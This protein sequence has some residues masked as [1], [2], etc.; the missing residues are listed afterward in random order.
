MILRFF[1]FMAEKKYRFSGFVFIMSLLMLINSILNPF[2]SFSK[3]EIIT[4]YFY[5]PS[6]I[7]YSYNFIICG[8]LASVIENS[9]N[10]L[11]K[12]IRY[13]NKREYF[14][15]I[16]KN[17]FLLCL[18][19]VITILVL[20]FLSMIIYNDN[21]YTSELFE[22]FIAKQKL[23]DTPMIFILK[24]SIIF[25]FYFYFLSLFYY[26]IKFIT[27]NI[28]LSILLFYVLTFS[29]YIFSGYLMREREVNFLFLP[30][31]SAFYGGFKNLGEFSSA[32]GFLIALSTLIFYIVLEIV[33]LNY[34]LN[35]KDLE[36]SLK[37]RKNI[38]N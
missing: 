11:Y 33:I 34:L 8:F 28:N 16:L 12:L 3:V 21:T 7:G 20:S 5:F 13:Q 36:L 29:G 2:Y 25:F 23:T 27:K 18:F 17:L 22:N 24:K 30:Y 15:R 35:N 6:I 14:K 32:G 4:K 9:N 19:I 31:F 38:L 1:K 26:L 10:E 37:G